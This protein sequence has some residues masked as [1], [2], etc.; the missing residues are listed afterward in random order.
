MPR[1]KTGADSLCLMFIVMD[2]IIVNALT[3]GFVIFA[4][5]RY[6]I[7]SMGLFYTAVC[8]MG[9]DMVH[10]FFTSRSDRI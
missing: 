7:H 10:Y 4:Q 6:M 5:P 9:Y 8:M 2:G 1:L 3:V